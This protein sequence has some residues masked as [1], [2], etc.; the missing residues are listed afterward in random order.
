MDAKAVLEILK[1]HKGRAHGISVESLAARAGMAE[2][3][4]REAIAE[5][6][7]SGVPI[8]A[9]PG[10]GYYMAATKQDLEKT[11]KFLHARALHSLGLEAQLRKTSL[12]DLAGQLALE[13]QAQA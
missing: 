3:K 6:R 10:T 1:G 7:K 5:L 2:R 9:V 8:C 12:G 11:L 13:V 4:V